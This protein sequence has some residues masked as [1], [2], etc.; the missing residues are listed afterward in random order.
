MSFYHSLLQ[1]MTQFFELRLHFMDLLPM[2]RLL[3][4]PV[5]AFD[6]GEATVF[7]SLK[8]ENW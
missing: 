1:N 3:I 5:C 8:I 6:V 7:S 2:L 4:H